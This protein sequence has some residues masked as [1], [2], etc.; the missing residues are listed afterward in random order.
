M[1]ALHN[2]PLSTSTQRRFTCRWNFTCPLAI[3]KDRIR[4]CGLTRARAGSSAKT[5]LRLDVP[6]WVYRYE[7][8][9]GKWMRILP[10]TSAL[11]CHV[12]EPQARYAHQ[13]VYD[14]KTGQTFMH[15]GNGGVSSEPLQK[16]SK[17]EGEVEGDGGTRL[18][19]FWTM[20]LER[21]GPYTC[22]S[23]FA[24]CSTC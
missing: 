14:P 16:Q 13:L 12:E 10:G 6:K 7:S 23:P 20:T 3:L 9:P 15:G 8:Y 2:G 21:C 17:Q 24:D 4:I 19:D 18:D 5:E 11:E 1:R 22:R